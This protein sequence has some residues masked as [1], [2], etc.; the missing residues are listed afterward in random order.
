MN[1]T[2]VM[3]FQGLDGRE[4]PEMQASRE[5]L[6]AWLER[7]AELETEAAVMWRRLFAVSRQAGW[8]RMPKLADEHDRKAAEA[9][10]QIA[11]MT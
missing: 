11:R 2:A 5:L 8:Y 4:R 7:R 3:M 9:R 6:R 10:A 1:V